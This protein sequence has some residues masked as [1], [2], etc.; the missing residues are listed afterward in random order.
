MRAASLSDLV[1]RCIGV[2]AINP[3][4][5]KP[6]G[7]GLCMLAGQGVPA[8]F[9]PAQGCYAPCLKLIDTKWNN[10]QAEA[11]QFCA[12]TG[13]AFFVHARQ[14]ASPETTPT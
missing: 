10:V 7:Q 14:R 9:P 12:S 13:G 3:K 8:V 11:L 4:I 1:L 5:H 2:Q 6:V